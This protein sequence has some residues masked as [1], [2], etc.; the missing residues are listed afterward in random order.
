M[1]IK[2]RFNFKQTPQDAR[3]IAQIEHTIQQVCAT[4]LKNSNNCASEILFALAGKEYNNCTTNCPQE[5]YQNALKML[6]NFYREAGINTD[7]MTIIDSSGVS[8]YSA[9]STNNLTDAIIYLNK[10]YNIRNFL[11]TANEGTL[12]KRLRYLENQLWAK[13]GT[14][15]GLS[16][17]AGIIKTKNEQELAFAIIIQDFTKSKSAL[18]SIEDD[19][20]DCM[21]NL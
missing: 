3:K 16:S 2:N 21:F 5:I 17:I 7:K 12:T 18:K 8:R 14:M 1:P 4:I 11:T 9:L 10:N 13:T 6:E 15:R 20:I 19:L